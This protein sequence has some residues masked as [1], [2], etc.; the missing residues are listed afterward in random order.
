MTGEELLDV[1]GECKVQNQHEFRNL[2]NLVV[3]RTDRNKEFKVLP[4]ATGQ[5]TQ[6]HNAEARWV[7]QNAMWP[8]LHLQSKK[9]SKAFFL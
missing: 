7:N 9:H 2:M 5:D 8:K 4:E 1:L 3:P 6:S